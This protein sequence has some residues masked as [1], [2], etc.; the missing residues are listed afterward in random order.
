[1]STSGL[2]AETH[3]QEGSELNLTNNRHLVA[4]TDHLNPYGA[5]V[6]CGPISWNLRGEVNKTS[7]WKQ[8]LTT[9]GI[10][11]PSNTYIGR[12]KA[13][14]L[15]TFSKQASK[16]QLKNVSRRLVTKFMLQLHKLLKCP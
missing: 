7:Q 13:E 5:Q 2:F 16:E 4:W 6:G 3:G 15:C 12:S 8:T 9:A 11:W 14:T 1:M 10:C